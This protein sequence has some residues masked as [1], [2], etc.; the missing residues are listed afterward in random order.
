[1]HVHE[2]AGYVAADELQIVDDSKIWQDS[3]DSSRATRDS[4]HSHCALPSLTNTTSPL[5][6]C[7]SG[8]SAFC[9]SS[10][11][12][13]VCNFFKLL[14]A[15]FR[16]SWWWRC[17]PSFRTLLPSLPVNL[18]SSAPAARS[19]PPFL[20]SFPPFYPLSPCSGLLQAISSTHKYSKERNTKSLRSLAHCN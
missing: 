20:S 10:I 1:M 6:S 7:A 11:I 14:K 12:H 15:A 16:P 3:R 13:L 8:T 17:P 19:S 2:L 18:C 4:R 5:L 9:P